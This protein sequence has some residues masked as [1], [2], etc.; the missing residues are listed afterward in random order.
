MNQNEEG[1]EM[2]CTSFLKKKEEQEKEK[3][4]LLFCLVLPCFALFCS[5][6]SFVCCC[7]RLL[8][9]AALRWRGTPAALSSHGASSSGIRCS[10]PST[11]SRLSWSLVLTSFVFSPRALFVGLLVVCCLRFSQQASTRKFH[12]NSQPKWQNT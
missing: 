2:W 9:S 8:F 11:W 10:T 7:F 3:V 1:V 6:L 12:T 4:H 5:V